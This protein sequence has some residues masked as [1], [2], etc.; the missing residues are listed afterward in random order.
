MAT[1]PLTCWT[2]SDATPDSIPPPPPIIHSDTAAVLADIASTAVIH[3]KHSNSWS[4]VS[5]NVMEGAGGGGTRTDEGRGGELAAADMP[6]GRSDLETKSP[7][8]AP[9]RRLMV[10]KVRAKSSVLPA[11]ALR[12]ARG[13]YRLQWSRAVSGGRGAVH[14]FMHTLSPLHHLRV[15]GG[16]LGAVHGVLQESCRGSG[17]GPGSLKPR[18]Q[19]DGCHVTR[20]DAGNVCAVTGSDSMESN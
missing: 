18:V 19:A 10:I 17:D 7:A 20:E 11:R 15:H 12:L 3:Y 16:T 6:Q 9:R 8:E 14:M 4:V 1:F 2:I 5:A 13:C